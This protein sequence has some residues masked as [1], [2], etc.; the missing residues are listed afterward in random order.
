MPVERC[1][2]SSLFYVL[3]L[4]ALILLLSQVDDWS[5][6]IFLWMNDGWALTTGFANDGE[7]CLRI[8][9]ALLLTIY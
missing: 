9:W 1:D 7:R 3:L 4:V 6:I 2:K 8:V 5:S